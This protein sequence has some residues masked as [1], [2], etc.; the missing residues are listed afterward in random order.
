M[1]KVGDDYVLMN[2]GVPG[3]GILT[4]KIVN[5]YEDSPGLWVVI[6]REPQTGTLIKR[7]RTSKSVKW[8]TGGNN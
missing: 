1:F 2:H 6:V 5:T 7:L 4:G 8:A 3:T